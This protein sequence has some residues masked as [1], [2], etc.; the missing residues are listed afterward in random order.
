MITYLLKMQNSFFVKLD[1]RLRHITLPDNY[2]NYTKWP[3]KQQESCK[4]RTK[5]AQTNLTCLWT[6]HSQLSGNNA[7]DF[8]LCSP[9]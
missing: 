4:R 6:Y 2:E 3:K 7:R 1:K 9:P 8:E 5:A